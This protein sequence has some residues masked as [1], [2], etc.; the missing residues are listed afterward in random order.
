AKLAPQFVGRREAL[1]FG[2]KDRIAGAGMADKRLG[3]SAAQGAFR[4]GLGLPLWS[5]APG[6]FPFRPG[7]DL[8][9]RCSVAGLAQTV[10]H[11]IDGIAHALRRDLAHDLCDASAEGDAAS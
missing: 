10:Q 2:F 7:P 9:A 6:S 8:G 1:A 5:R 3:A 4:V 11:A